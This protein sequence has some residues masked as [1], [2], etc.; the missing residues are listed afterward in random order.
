MEKLRVELFDLRKKRDGMILELGEFA[1]E[2]NDL[3]E[4]SS[5]I[6]MEQKIQFVDAQIKR[7]LDEFNEYHRQK[8]VVKHIEKMKKSAEKIRT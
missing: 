3:R 8:K 2:N 6:R 7:I 1:Q 5:Y 4:N